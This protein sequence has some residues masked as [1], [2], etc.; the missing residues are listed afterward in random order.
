[1]II[2][3]YNA[4]KTEIEATL[5]T[6]FDSLPQ[7]GTGLI[8]FASGPKNTPTLIWGRASTNAKSYGKTCNDALKQVRDA[9]G[10]IGVLFD[11]D[12]NKNNSRAKFADEIMSEIA[13][14]QGMIWVHSYIP[15]PTIEQA[16]QL[17]NCMY[18]SGVFSAF[19][20]KLEV[21]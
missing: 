8:I 20:K 7:D 1:M 21:A 15:T 6:G 10:D 2:N 11:A 14:H 13:K 17:K 4:M 18:G 9:D 16:T 3:Y 19:R 12:G 5:K